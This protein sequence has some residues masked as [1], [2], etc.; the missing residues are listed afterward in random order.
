MG[1][2]PLQEGEEMRKFAPVLLLLCSLFLTGCAALFSDSVSRDRIFSYVNENREKLE[3]LQDEEMKRTA[4]S[5]KDDIKK[6]LGYNT[7]VKNVYAYND[8]ILQFY[9]GGSGLSVNSTYTGFYY[10]RGDTPYAMEFDGCDLAETSPGIFEWQNE[11][12]SH[13]IYTEK[14]SENWYYYFQKYN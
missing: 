5:E 10:S 1:L 3:A 11:D 9:C 7:I 2:W 13:Y 6:A 12:G 4:R 14:I 8:G